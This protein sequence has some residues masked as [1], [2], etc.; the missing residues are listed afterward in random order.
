MS[1]RISSQSSSISMSSST[2]GSTSTSAN[3]VWR[4]FWASNGL[5]RTRRWTPRSG[6]EPAV[7][8][9][10]LDR[11]GH[12]LEAGLLALLLVDDL[13]REAVPLGP[14]QVHPQQHLRPVG[15]LGPA[16]A[17]ADREQRGT[18]VVFAGEQQ[19]GPFAA[20][21]RLESGG[22]AFELGLELG[23]GGLR[24]EVD[25][26][27]EV[28]GSPEE[29]F[30]QRDLLAQPVGLAE[31]LLS[32]ALIVPEA[33]LLGQRVELCDSS[34]LGRKVKASPRSRGSARPGRGWRRR[35]PSSGPADPGA[36]SA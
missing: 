17:G 12:A 6:A 8:A 31:D 33:R 19:R 14:A 2:S 11:H 34:V 35:P 7:R 29:A 36:G 20:E 15:R 27:E 4:R 23:V 24:E 25:G 10:S 28:V 21:A 13:G 22:V 9:P 16:G 32:G 30:P 18:L 1:T 5:I 3:V 26:G